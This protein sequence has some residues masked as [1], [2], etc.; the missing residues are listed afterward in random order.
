MPLSPVPSWA[1]RSEWCHL[2]GAI[3]NGA[4]LGDAQL[5]SAYLSGADLNGADLTG[6]DLSGTDLSDADLIA[7]GLSQQQLDTVHSCTNADPSLQD[8]TAI[9]S[10]RIT[11]T[12]WYTE[13][14]AEA[15]VIRKLIGQFEQQY[16]E[17]HIN[18]V[19]TN[20]FQTQTAF[21][22]AA[23][24]GNAPDVLRSDVSWVAQFASQGYLLNI[25]SYIP[26]GDLSD[27]LSAPLSYDYYN[28]HL[29]G[30]P[31]VTDFLALLYNKAELKKA[32]ITSPPATMADLES[33]AMKVVQQ[34]KRQH[35]DL[36]QMGQ[37]TTCCRSSMLSVV[38]CSTST[39]TFW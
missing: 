6:T 33:D 7:A 21:A 36:K 23:Q 18:A 12:Y 19:N 38:A 37:A 10:L 15:P 17:I 34:T 22:V 4:V 25:D 8:L 14:P 28:G 16:P 31:Q 27:Y 26:Q 30:L 32:G 3:L 20:Y 13:S 2:T 24:E 9:I 1:T 39:T 35:T 5:N 29:Y 11:L